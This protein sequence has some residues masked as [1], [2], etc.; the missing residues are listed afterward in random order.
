MKFF[1]PLALSANHPIWKAEEL[2]LPEL[3]KVKVQ[4]HSFFII[5]REPSSN[6]VF[7]LAGGQ[8][9]DASPRHVEAKYS[10]FTYSSHFGFS[11]PTAQSGLSF[12][13]YDSM[14]ALSEDGEYFRVRKK[15]IKVELQ[16][17]VHYSK[18]LVWDDVIIDTWL[19]PDPPWHIRIHRIESKRRLIT[20]EGGFALGIP[21]DDSLDS[22]D[23][24]NGHASMC[25]YNQKGVSGIINWCGDRESELVKAAPNSNLLEGRTVIPSLK[26]D[27]PKGVHILVC[28]VLGS[29]EWSR[30]A[31][32]WQQMPMIELAERTV[33]ILNSDRQ[34]TAL[35]DTGGE[36]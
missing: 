23:E 16:G 22:M 19:I 26:G 7:T 35:I 5:C 20:V 14:L 27:L 13:A 31:E 18:W 34:E 32:L 24:S 21:T 11:V 6:H 28:A 3:E 10:K 1:L 36:Q 2:P 4:P 25:L 8:F 33:R 9:N 15:C 17:N 12:G 30:I 29:P